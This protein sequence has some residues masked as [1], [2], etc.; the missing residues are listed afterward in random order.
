MLTIGSEL[1]RNAV[2]RET[3]APRR[4]SRRN[5]TSGVAITAK[6]EH[7]PEV[8][9][10][11]YRTTKR[12]SLYNAAPATPTSTAGIFAFRTT[13]LLPPIPRLPASFRPP[14]LSTAG[15]GTAGELVFGYD[16]GYPR[17]AD[18][19]RPPQRVHGR[20]PRLRLLPLASYTRRPRLV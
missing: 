5:T 17:G 14:P 4:S 12:P 20:P 8:R 3:T 9:P 6:P 11:Q 16:R 7:D 18:H 13:P 19:E 1:P 2:E 15:L 10:S